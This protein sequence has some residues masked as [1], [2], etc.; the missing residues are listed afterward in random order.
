MSDTTGAAENGEYTIDELSAKTG[1]PSR[2]IRFYQAKGVLASPRKRGRVAVYDHAHVERL[3]LVNELQDKGLRLRAIKELLS[4]PD[5]DAETIQEWLGIG[6]QIG[7][8]ALDEPQLMTEAQV[9]EALGGEVRRGVI[10]ELVRSG[11]IERRGEG[12]T[13]RFLVDSP[14]LL[15]ISGELQKAGVSLDVA[16]TMRQILEKRLRR[17][18]EELVDYAIEHIGKGFG[19]SDDPRDVQEAVEALFPSAPGGEA[20]RVIFAREISRVASER[21]QHGSA[22]SAIVEAG[23]RRSR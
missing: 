3:E 19:R 8:Y 9:K 20:V 15:R 13:A 14:A 21:L 7:T 12:V 23:R 1:I 11:A 2:T 6:Q 18:A 17:A 22:A 16:I 5:T 10:A 4:R